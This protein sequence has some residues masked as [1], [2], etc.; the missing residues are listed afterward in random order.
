MKHLFR[1]VLLAV[2]LV[3]SF[4]HSGS[5]S[6]QLFINPIGGT[7]LAT[8]GDDFSVGPRSLGFTG[9][10]FGSS[11]TN[12]F[13]NSNG[14]LTFG[15]GD[16]TFTN[17]S[18]PNASSPRIAPFF[19]DLFLPPGSIVE[20]TGTGYYA[21][22]WNGVG[23]FGAGGAVTAQAALFGSGNTL[24]FQNG[25]I[26]FSY[27]LVTSASDNSVTVG[28]NSGNGT[29][30]AV[31]PGFSGSGGILNDVQ[32]RA[33]NNTRWLFHPI[34][35][36]AYNVSLYTGVPEPGLFALIPAVALGFGAVYR[37]RRK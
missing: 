8:A 19:D 17:S 31:L 21:A 32:A 30:S 26:L 22:T 4:L 13:V 3:P 14:N 34:N 25:D 5:A 16:T 28:L 36:S 33:L 23:T 12:V 35:G 1:I 11:Q 18:F 7:T 2:I 6:A 27:G 29:T 24:G 10:F 15:S 20:N 9:T 37:R